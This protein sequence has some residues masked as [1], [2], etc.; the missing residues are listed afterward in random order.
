MIKQLQQKF[1]AVNMLLVSF[2]LLAVFSIQMFSAYRRAREQVQQAQTQALQWILQ[3]FHPGYEFGDP[4]REDRPRPPAQFPTVPVF[5][6]EINKNGQV[7]ALREGPGTTVARETAQELVNT[8]LLNNRDHGSISEENLSYLFREENDRCFFAFADDHI[9]SSSVQNQFLTSL[10]I[11]TL[12]LSIFY[13]ISRF[14]AKLALRPAEQA[15]NQQRQF[16]ADASHELK[17]PIT[18]ILANIGIIAAHPDDLVGEQVKWINYIQ[19]EAIRMKTLVD[20]LLFLAKSDSSRLPVHPAQI[21]LDQLVT[22]SL[23]PFE[24]VAFE[25]GVNLTDKIEPDI[26]VLGDEVQ[27]RRL[28]VILLDNAVK[29][30]GENGTVC[31]HL[32]RIHGRPRLCVHNTGPAIPAEHLPHLFERFYRSDTARDRTQGG[33]GLGLSI[34][35]SVVDKHSGKISVTSTP[36]DGTTFTVVFPKK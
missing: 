17:T 1:I 12:A 25:S 3:E 9:I 27:L 23:L 34:A 36:K 29:Y 31:V 18:V 28:T 10:L 4:R 20:D 33:Y 13:L 30:A 8:A 35:K 6:V 32:D 2:V 21:R 14:L 24:S 22:G 26:T 19:D 15:W 7:V 5:A 11:F 16:V